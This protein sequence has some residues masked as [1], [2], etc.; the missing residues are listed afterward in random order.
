MPFLKCLI[1]IASFSIILAFTLSNYVCAKILEVPAQY[2]SIQEAVLQ[3]RSGDEIKVAA[4]TYK[5]NVILQNNL[6]LSGEDAKTTTITTIT[7][8]NQ[9]LLTISGSC[10]ASGFTFM[11]G[12]GGKHGTIYIPDGSPEISLNIIRGNESI[13]ISVEGNSTPLIKENLI[14][15]NRGTGINISVSTPT[16]LMNEIFKNFGAGIYSQGSNPRIENNS[17]YENSEAGV[18]ISFGVGRGAKLSTRTEGEAI[19]L[20]NKIENNSSAG[21]VAENTSPTIIGNTIANKGRP[22]LLL[23]GSGA[24]IQKNHLISSGPPAIHIN[25]GSSPIIENNTISGT[26]RF[27]ILGDTSNATIKNN[28]MDSNWQPK[29]QFK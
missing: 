4:G 29:F 8:F 27:P 1:H 25:P 19:I 6:T 20:N 9:P 21:L 28:K 12:S 16:I 5:E 22:A 26:R 17:I 23:F 24:I 11:G 2:S 14:F 3:A 10:K 18:S 7:N 13:G 15:N